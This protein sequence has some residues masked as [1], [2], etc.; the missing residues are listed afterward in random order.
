[1]HCLSNVTITIS[2]TSLTGVIRFSNALLFSKFKNTWCCASIDPHQDSRDLNLHVLEARLLTYVI[3]QCGPNKGEL[4]SATEEKE[5]GLLSH[6]R[7]PHWWHPGIRSFSGT[8]TRSCRA[9]LEICVSEGERPQAGAE[10]SGASAPGRG[11]RAQPGPF[12]AS[13]HL[14]RLHHLLL[15]WSPS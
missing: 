7:R 3:P 2:V 15:L 12:P 10:G 11:P 8:W 6:L 4:F 14:P 13:P 9:N 5:K 1:M